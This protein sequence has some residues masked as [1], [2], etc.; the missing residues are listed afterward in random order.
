MRNRRRKQ[1]ETSDRALGAVLVVVGL[2]LVSALAGGAWWL[3]HS[4]NE[5][6]KETNCALSG[7]PAVHMILVDRSDP[8]SGQQSQQIRQAINRIKDGAIEGERFDFFVFEG[9]AKSVL[10]P[11]L[12][13]CSPEHP[14][15]AQPLIENPEHIA[16]RYQHRFADAI[17]RMLEGLLQESER[18]TSPI[19]ESIRAAAITSFGPYQRKAINRRV[20]LVSDMIQHSDATSHY[21]SEPDFGTLSKD[22]IWPQLRPDLDSAQVGILYLLRPEAKRSGVTIQ[23]RGHQLFWEEYV[24]ASGGRITNIT[25]F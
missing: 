3:R 24:T 20:T 7:P 9:D 2:L 15:D 14:R 11:I 4:R 21:R 18:P 23:N 16:E 10:K 17:D 19:M 5:I 25:P 12:S 8:I 13:V 22:P 6:D 1:K